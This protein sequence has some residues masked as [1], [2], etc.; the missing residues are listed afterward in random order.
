V[1]TGSVDA[2]AVPLKV[3]PGREGVDMSVDKATVRVMLPSGFYENAYCGVFDGST[4]ADSKLSTIINDTTIDGACTAG[5]AYLVIFNGDGDSVLEH[6][7]KGLLVM[8]LPASLNSYDEFKVE[9]RPI[10]GA[11]LTVERMIPASLPT[12]GAVSLG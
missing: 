2:V 6:G 7:E 8:E 1:A 10:Q 9:I 11:A 3:S 12:D 5:F 4:L